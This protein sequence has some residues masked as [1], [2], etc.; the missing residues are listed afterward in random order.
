PTAVRVRAEPG[1]DGQRRPAEGSMGPAPPHQ[2]LDRAVPPEQ[3]RAAGRP[4]GGIERVGRR[5]AW[6]RDTG[7][8]VG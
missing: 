7:G 8:A 1:A 2:P 4:G 6:E 5:R 3:R